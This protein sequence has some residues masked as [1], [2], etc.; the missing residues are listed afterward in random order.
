MYLVRSNLETVLVKL[1]P[2][3]RAEEWGDCCR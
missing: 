1:L 2:G 3:H